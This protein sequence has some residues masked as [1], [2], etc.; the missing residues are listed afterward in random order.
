VK[1]LQNIYGRTLLTV[2]SGEEPGWRPKKAFA[3]ITKAPECAPFSFRI[4]LS[5]GIVTPAPSQAHPGSRPAEG[6]NA[7]QKANLDRILDLGLE[8]QLQLGRRTLL[9][10]DVVELAAGSVIELDKRVQEPAALLLGGR[11]IAHGEV[12][13]SEGNYALRVTEI[14]DVRQRLESV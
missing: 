2:G 10:R 8:L 3:L 4:L 11:V 13:L 1:K 9:L 14:C 7:L 5:E 6:S 12:V